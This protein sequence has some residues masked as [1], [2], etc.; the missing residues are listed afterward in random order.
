MMQGIL[1]LARIFAWLFFIG[2]PAVVVVT[3]V[4]SFAVDR[5]RKR[6]VKL[7]QEAGAELSFKPDSGPSASE[8][9]GIIYCIGFVVVG[10]VIVVAGVLGITLPTGL[11]EDMENILGT[12]FS[13]IFA[14]LLWAPILWS[15]YYYVT[16]KR[17]IKRKLEEALSNKGL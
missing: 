9:E 16:E 10:A 7:A 8:I 1:D 4:V 2:L 5:A 12:V 14:V 3:V 6:A 15:P 13:G 11:S 17:R